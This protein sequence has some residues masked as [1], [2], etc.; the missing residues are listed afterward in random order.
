MGPVI[1][2]R[3]LGPT[4]T[5]GSRVVATHKRDA[6]TTYRKVVEWDHA[7]DG[8]ENHRAAADALIASWPLTFDAV[9]VG[10]GHDDGAYYWLVVGRWQVDPAA[11]D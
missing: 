7:L 3:Y 10:R 11:A 2:T 6:E 8:P 5:R 9:I 4:S 1:V